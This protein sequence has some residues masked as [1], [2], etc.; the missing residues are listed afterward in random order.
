MTSPKRLPDLQRDAKALA[1]RVLA[2]DG[3][4]D[5]TSEV[6]G[7]AGVTAS[8]VVEYRSGGVL[9]GRVYADA[10]VHLC[11]CGPL[12]WIVGDGAVVAPGS[13]VARVRGDLAAILRAE[14][15]LLNVLQ[16]ACGIATATNAFVRAVAG[17][18]CRVLHTRKTAPGLRILDAHAV[19]AGGGA[20]HRLD[21]GSAVL[22][23]DNHW[24]LLGRRGS[25]L[26]AACD[27]ARARG[28]SGIYVE[29]ESREQVTA[30]CLAGATRL[31]VDNQS[32]M[33]FCRLAELARTLAPGIEMEATGGVTL[34][35]AREYAESGAGFVSVGALT[36]SVRAA[37][38]A[39]EIEE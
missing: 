33:E 37:D 4:V 14:R 3:A 9:A 15:S 25:S 32:P 10:V 28:V 29:V 11:G 6:V 27:A 18:G 19:L 5:V 17:T 13:V 35:L 8:G 20:L 1:E 36:H 16:R 34:E 39:L 23:K 24:H 38:I 30:A 7:A 26:R 22:V 31:L 21:L 12:D 2:E